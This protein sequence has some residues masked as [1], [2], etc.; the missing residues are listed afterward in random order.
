MKSGIVIINKEKGDTSQTV[1]SKV[2]KI[3]NVKKAGHIGT[4]D[5][6]A[7][8]VLPVLIGSATKLSKYLIEHDKTYIATLKLGIKK[9]TGDE[10]GDVLEK[11]EVENIDE[12]TV[13]NVL[14]EMQG[15]QLQAPHKFSAIK[16]NGKKLY[17]YSREGIKIEIPKREIEIYSIKLISIN[18]EKKE[19][20]FEVACSKGTYIRVLCEDI[21]EK[22]GTVGYMKELQRTEV[23]KFNIKNSILLEKL[24]E[25]NIISVE[26]LCEKYERIDLND[27][28]LELFLNGVMLTINVE[29]GLYRVY[30]NQKFIGLGIVKNELIKRDVVF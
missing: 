30:N 1:V 19:I 20:T 29:N 2:K 21:A 5:P 26:E 9:D 3:L 25:E 22:L 14:K 27:R 6:L 18:D 23:D 24:T 10:E 12:K 16:I 17:E 8:G 28:K 4:L 11:R 7:T 13:Q 15:K